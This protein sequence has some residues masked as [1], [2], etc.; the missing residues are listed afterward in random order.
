MLFS[1]CAVNGSVIV[2]SPHKTSQH[3]H[4]V[5]CGL[6]RLRWLLL[7]AGVMSGCTD[8]SGSMLLW[9]KCHL[10]VRT[11]APR[12]GLSPVF[13][14]HVLYITVRMVL[15]RNRRWDTGHADAQSMVILFLFYI[16]TSFFASWGQEK[17]ADTECNTDKWSP[18]WQIL[19]IVN[20]CLF[21][22]PADTVWGYISIDLKSRLWSLD[23]FRIR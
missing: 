14:V 22:H 16:N 2:Q 13:L 10:P 19:M 5:H 6:L 17:Q 8:D 9:R 12:T 4:F 7:A 18:F 23:E 3:Y 1:E 20:S 21:K 15:C 11:D